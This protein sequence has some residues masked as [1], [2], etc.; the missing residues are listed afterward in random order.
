MIDHILL[1]TWRA[2]YVRNE[3]THSK[4][5]PTTESSKRFLISYVKILRNLKVSS[6]EDIIKGKQPMLESMYQS[7]PCPKEPPDKRWTKPPA[8][9]VKLNCDGSVKVEDESAGAGMVLR[10]ENGDTI[11]SA[12]RKLLNCLDPLDAEVRA[13][14][15]GLLLAMR[16]SDK[17]VVL[18]LDCKVLVD[19]IKEKNQDRSPFVHTISFIRNLCSSTRTIYT[20]KVDRSQNRMSHCLANLARIEGQTDIWIGSGPEGLSQVYDQDILVSPI[21]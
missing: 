20:V 11:F 21:I 9:W 15:E 18:E 8:G 5:L 10:D 16:W 19:A 17:P 12:C 4:P 13:C 1:I 3:V 7:S 6:T 2:W 14:E